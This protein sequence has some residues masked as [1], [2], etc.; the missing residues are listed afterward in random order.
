MKTTARDRV[1]R[2]RTSS[3]QPEDSV[4]A[5]RFPNPLIRGITRPAPRPPWKSVPDMLFR[6]IIMWAQGAPTD[7]TSPEC[8]TDS[9]S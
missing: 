9:G 7:S 3:V 4:P 6:P 1:T 8:E 2:D 5:S